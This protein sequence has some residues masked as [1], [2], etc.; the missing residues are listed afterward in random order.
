MQ[1]FRKRFLG[2]RNSQNGFS[3]FSLPWKYSGN[4]LKA[5]LYKE[6]W[7][8]RKKGQPLSYFPSLAT[9]NTYV[10]CYTHPHSFS[11]LIISMY[12]H[13]SL[14]RKSYCNS[15]CLLNGEVK[16]LFPTFPKQRRQKQKLHTC[17]RQIDSRKNSLLL[18]IPPPSSP[19]TVFLPV[20]PP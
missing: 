1:N 3:L 15:T 14:F 16:I 2:R 12:T 11:R 4:F 20:S 19:L 8:C 10:L 5:C 6:M 13:F 18:F 7:R 17:I 9:P